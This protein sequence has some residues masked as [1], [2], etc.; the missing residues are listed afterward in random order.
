MYKALVTGGAGFIGSYIVE[1]LVRRGFSVVALDNLSLGNMDNIA[2]LRKQKNLEFIQGSIS[3]LSLLQKLSS[4]V[5][6]VFHQAAIPNIPITVTSSNYISY[7]ETNSNG[8]LNILQA[9]K[10][11]NVKKVICA[12]SCSVYGNEPTIPKREDM[13]PDPRSPYAVI[14]LIAEYY[15]MIFQRVHFL[16]TVCLRYFNV[17]GPR[18][19]PTSAL[20]SVIPKFIQRALSGKPPIIFGDGQQTRDFVYVRDVVSANLQAAESDSTGIFNIGTGKGV[21][22]NQLTQSIL[23]LTNRSDIQ[24]VYENEIPDEIRHSVADISRAQT[25]G[26]KPKYTL[27]EGLK[28]TIGKKS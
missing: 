22:L 10:D 12:S 23:K 19:N 1:E 18:Q 2:H 11:N 28:E 17:Y 5:R 24:P 20:A 9:A 27:E 4:E 15:C 26:Y 25:F 21:S 16:P 3:D 6:Y 14:K 8:I 13:I 7:Y